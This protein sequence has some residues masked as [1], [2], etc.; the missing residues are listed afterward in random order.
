MGSV[1]SRFAN[2]GYMA[3]Q[4]LTSATLVEN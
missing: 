2:H 1:G 4:K 3:S